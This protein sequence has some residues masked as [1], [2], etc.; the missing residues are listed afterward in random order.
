MRQRESL[1]QEARFQFELQQA[2]LK[3]QAELL[4]IKN[5]AQK[6][7]LLNRQFLLQQAN[8]I[9]DTSFSDLKFEAL[10]RFTQSGGDGSFIANFDLISKEAK[11]RI[12]RG[13]NP[14]T[15]IK[16]ARNKYSSFLSSH[17]PS[18]AGY[19]PASFTTI[20]QVFG[21][22]VAEKIDLEYNPN[23]QGERRSRL[24][25]VLSVGSAA[26]IAKN[27]TAISNPE[28]RLLFEKTANIV[29]QA[30]AEADNWDKIFKKFT[31][32]FGNPITAEANPEI[33]K[34]RV[35]TP[36]GE[37]VPFRSLELN[38]V[39]KFDK[40]DFLRLAESE[41]NKALLKKARAIQAYHSG[42]D[43]EKFNPETTNQTVTGSQ[44]QTSSNVQSILPTA[45]TPEQITKAEE[46]QINNPIPEFKDQFEAVSSVLGAS[47]IKEELLFNQKVQENEKQ[48]GL[49]KILQGVKDLN[50]NFEGIKKGDKE[51]ERK[52]ISK[53]VK[54]NL[55]KLSSKD[56]LNTL[57]GSGS[58]SNASGLIDTLSEEGLDPLNFL[59][60]F[61]KNPKSIAGDKDA[62]ENIK[63][64]IASG[65][66]RR[67]VD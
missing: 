2:P 16:S 30:D 51:K 4:R 40:L 27:A 64:A 39:D 62:L 49:T 31:D 21:P 41:R 66:A 47:K 25:T 13:E 7:E 10:D 54:D 58:G 53:K 50:I 48:L 42:V 65:L 52:K 37:T 34:Q 14:D 8:E 63:F 5:E 29:R 24:A 18:T 60:S 46:S 36:S 28:E 26:D 17:T 33:S 59:S 56:L 61:S 43:P 11:S 67:I 57:F 12:A 15:A 20:S 35:P 23:R 55:D 3:A 22:E 38:S 6:N 44:G 45:P 1:M 9:V 19:G 32:D